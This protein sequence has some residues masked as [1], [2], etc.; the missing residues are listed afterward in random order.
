M[1]ILLFITGV[2]VSSIM[3]YYNTEKDTKYKNVSFT[4]RR[5]TKIMTCG[6]CEK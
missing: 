6:I 3:Y 1:Y 5:K 2:D 4:E